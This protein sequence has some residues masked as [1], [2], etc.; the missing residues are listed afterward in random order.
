MLTEL[1]RIRGKI[2]HEILKKRART[3]ETDE[4][5]WRYCVANAPRMNYNSP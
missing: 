2:E 1:I 5:D 3:G 4:Y